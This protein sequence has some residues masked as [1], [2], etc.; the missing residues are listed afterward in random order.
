MKTNWI[1]VA[2]QAEV[3]IYSSD[4]LPGNLS[5]VDV[6]SNKKGT[7]HPRD[8]VSDA[9]GRAFDS[10]GSG[11]HAMEPNTGVKEKQ[12]RKFVKKMVGRLQLARVKGD[13]DQLVLLAAPAVLGVIRKTLTPDLE[14]TVI[15]E[16]SKDL[17][18]QGVDKVQ[19]QLV[20][21]FALR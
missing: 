11:R 9:P 3:Q 7:A 21:A 4:R 8:L 10:R 1:L 2:N 15:K 13:F 16:I 6:L 20:R 14:K 5:L 18:G 19:S 17:I 12:R